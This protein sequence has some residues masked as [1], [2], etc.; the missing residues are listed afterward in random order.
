[1][2]VHIP[3]YNNSP[4]NDLFVNINIVP[5]EYNDTIIMSLQTSDIKLLILLPL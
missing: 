5:N 1:M 4:D 2:P 3:K